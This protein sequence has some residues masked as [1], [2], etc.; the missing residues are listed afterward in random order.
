[1]RTRERGGGADGAMG[2][3]TSKR[4]RR[5]LT[6]HRP[7][8]PHRVSSLLSQVLLEATK[9]KHSHRSSARKV[10]HE[11]Y[12]WVR[13]VRREIRSLSDEDRNRYFGALET[14]YNTPCNDGKLKYGSAFECIETFT[15]MHNDLAGDPYC[16]H[17]HDG[18]GF[19]T[20]HAA[21]SLWFERGLQAVDGALSLPYWDYTIDMHAVGMAGGDTSKWR[22]SI[23]WDDDWFGTSSPSRVD[24]V[25]DTGRF[26]WTPV[27][28]NNANLSMWTNSYGMMRAPWNN[29]RAHY[30]TRSNQSYGF[31][32]TDLPGCASHHTVL[33]YENFSDFGF[34]ILYNPHGTTHLAIGGTWNADWRQKLKEVDY[35][36]QMAPSWTLLGFA[37]QK[38][39]FRGGDI[40]CPSY[41][42]LDVPEVE[43][44]C[45][46]PGIHGMIHSGKYHTL[47][48]ITMENMN[49][50]EY[51]RYGNDVSE[52]VYKL[53]CNYYDDTF[54]VM[55]DSLESAS[56][57]D[58][59]FWPT[60]PTVDRLFQWR[61]LNGM[62]STYWPDG[63]AWSVEGSK[64]GYCQGHDRGDVLP[65]T[66]LF[67]AHDGPYSNKELL[68]LMDPSM[69]SSPYIYDNFEWP[70]CL[71]EG[72]SIDL[73]TQN[74]IPD[75][76]VRAVTLPAPT[77]KINL[78]PMP[79]EKILAG[80]EEDR[81]AYEAAE[82]DE[83]A[84]QNERI[85][86]GGKMR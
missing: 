47:L 18:Y 70:H 61:R 5:S 2:W 43:C 1:M 7:P 49:A 69:S 73:M 53:L 50:Y 80:T 32:L 72:Y 34:H 28:V 14:I 51:D 76:N 68:N 65:F 64:T 83:I 17:A 16:D 56:P 54:A 66:E 39:M 63:K 3:S 62:P 78:A 11:D 57:A 4:F 23:V 52:V 46:C 44:K 6:K 38:N 74:G 9:S 67:D 82:A 26:A 31:T 85:A 79:L 36:L 81:A 37:K 42:A 59:S 10:A 22:D 21:L 13:Y 29:N 24:H 71:D 15:S 12:V 40:T 20:M 35:D 45:E 19:L 58:V 84:A 25:I 77:Q 55:G 33:Q 60:H 86:R 27:K 30:V 8:P 48:D 75:G 41:C